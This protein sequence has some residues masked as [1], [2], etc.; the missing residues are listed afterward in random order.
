MRDN[1]QLVITNFDPDISQAAQLVTSTIGRPGPKEVLINNTHV[2]INAIY[3]RE[4]YKG[5]VP[6]IDVD[7]PYVFG[8]EA[9]GRV[10]EVG[11]DVTHIHANDAVS[12][13]KVGTAYQE[14]QIV[15]SNV[16]VK[17]PDDTPQYLTINPTGISAHLALEKV[18]EI[19]EGETVVVSAAAGGLGHILVQLCKLKGCHV[20][21]ICGTTEK[22]ELLTRLGACDRIINYRQESVSAVLAK[23]YN[24]K[25]DV[26]IDSVGQHMFDAFLQQLAPK[27]RLVVCGLATELSSPQF[28]K[29]SQ[30]RVYESIYWKGASVR[31]FMNH[32]FKDNHQWSR[33]TLTRLYQQGQLMVEVD[34]TL[35]VG[36]GAIVEASSYLLA[37][38]SKGK[39]IVSL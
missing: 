37:G 18:A 14:Y 22:E 13:V 26:A 32:L 29:V 31:C 21:G 9:V 2:G 20:V 19:Q 10:V 35:F 33:E 30:P 6:Y 24:D 38:K 3:D 1:Q 8:V 23:E 16:A 34:P 5:A 7:F 17:I 27:G 15:E 12:T 36:V 11:S 25:I 28:E 39:V 4:L